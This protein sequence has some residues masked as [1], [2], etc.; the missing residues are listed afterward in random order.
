MIRA[1]YFV[2]IFCVNILGFCLRNVVLFRISQNKQAIPI[3]FDFVF[4]KLLKLATNQV[5]SREF[6]LIV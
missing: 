2:R 1:I 3:F 6:P 4:Q 5:E